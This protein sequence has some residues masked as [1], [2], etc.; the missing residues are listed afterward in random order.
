M[1][2]DKDSIFII[3]PS[4]NEEKMVRSS[5]ERLLAEGYKNIIVVDDGSTDCTYE[6]IKDL[7]IY[8]I[9][10]SINRGLGTALSTG[11]QAAQLLDA[12]IVVTFDADGQHDPKDIEKLAEPILAGKADAAIGSRAYEASRFPLKRF[13]YNKLANLVTF[14]LYGFSSSDTQSGLRAFSRKAVDK[15][16]IH[17]SKMECSSEI[18]YKVKHH[19]LRLKEVQI[20]PIYTDYSMSKGQ[21]FITGI[22]TMAR[23]ILNKLSGL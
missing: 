11:M 16:D 8:T 18:I 12:Q 21:N 2:V 5:I 4:Y 22:K 3:V 15:L 7:N 14:A 9:R 19:K 23:L 10:H 17:S 6:K 1:T 13:V 20:N